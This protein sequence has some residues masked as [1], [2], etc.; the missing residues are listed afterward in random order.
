MKKTLSSFLNK[1]YITYLF[2]I[3]TYA[4]KK[5]YKNVD[6][7][8]FSKTLPKNIIQQYKNK[9]KVFGRDVE[10]D[11]LLL[12]YNLSGVLDLNIVPENLFAA[13]IERELNPNKE[14]SFY[15]IKNIYNKWFN[16]KH[17]FP[18][19]YIHKIDGVIYDQDFNTISDLNMYM[20]NLD[21]SFPLILKPSKDTYG[22]AGVKT[23]KNDEELKN[24]LE[25]YE[26]MVCQEMITQNKDLNRINNSGIN[27]I[28]TCL[29]K[30]ENGKFEVLNNSIRFGINGSLDNETAGGIVCNIHED[31]SLN[32]YAVDKYANKYFKHP[33]SNIEFE[34]VKIPFYIDL[35]KTSKKIADEILFCN[36]VSLDMCLDENNHW[37][38]LEANLNWQTIRFAQYAGKGFFGKYTD[39]VIEKLAN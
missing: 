27:S 25:K 36:L 29:Y 16:N 32:K 13:I 2:Y 19:T 15:E 35:I 39:E 18:E 33:N 37:R 24:G 22:G 12:C 26:F 11:T 28:R 5:R 17:V 10:I 6:K 20:S 3:Q 8:L 14:I 23:I 1:S 7:K 21:I 31:G 9:W 38:C 34:K 30:T 4:F